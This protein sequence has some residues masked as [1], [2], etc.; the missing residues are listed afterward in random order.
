[1]REKM[2]LDARRELLE[3]VSERYR[4]ARVGEK[5]QILNQFLV[6]TGYSRKHAISLLNAP[7]TERRKKRTRQ[8]PRG[9]VPIPVEI[10]MA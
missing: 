7:R 2:S 10:R 1:M 5:T 9:S 6:T 8:A 4:F 3:S